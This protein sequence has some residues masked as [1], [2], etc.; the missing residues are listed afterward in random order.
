MQDEKE[1]HETVMDPDATLEKD[2]APP[3]PEHVQLTKSV[4][5]KRQ[6]LVSERSGLFR[7][8]LHLP[9]TICS[10]GQDGLSSLENMERELI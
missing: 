9:E 2:I 10:G 7:L 1:H 8:Y 3:F 5:V 6:Q 4:L